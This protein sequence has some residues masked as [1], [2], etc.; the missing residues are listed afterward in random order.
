MVIQLEATSSKPTP[1]KLFY[2][3]SHNDE[4]FRK[5]LETHLVLLQREGFILDWHDRKIRPGAEW[6]RAISDNL[7]AADLILL[8]VS[9]SFLASKYCRDIEVERAMERHRKGEAAVVPII[10]KACVYSN[11]KFAKLEPLPKT[12]RPL[13]EWRDSGFAQ[14]VEELRVLLVEL[15]YPRSPNALREGMH[16]HWYLKVKDHDKLAEPREREKI[17]ARLKDLTRDFTISLQGFSRWQI[18]DGKKAPYETLLI[19]NGSPEAF[20]ALQREK[21]LGKLSPALGVEVVSLYVGYAASVVGS[22]LP[23]EEGARSVEDGDFLLRPGRAVSP[24]VMKGVK[25]KDDD[26]G[27]LDFIVDRG[28]QTENEFIA[29]GE[30]ERHLEYFHAALTVKE[31]NMWVNL[32]AYEADRMLPKP[33]AGTRFG[34]DLLAQDVVLKQLTSSLMHPDS[35]VGRRYWDAVYERSREFYGTSK[36]PLN[37]FQKVWVVP[38]KAVVYEMP[39]DVPPPKRLKRFDVRTGQRFGYIVE[40]ELETLCE[41]DLLALRYDPGYHAEQ[42]ARQGS[43]FPVQIF[44]DLVLPHIQ[45]EVNEGEHFVPLRQIY[46]AL[47][48]ATWF[49]KKLRGTPAYERV[50]GAVDSDNPAS[51]QTSVRSVKSL[52]RA[53]GGSNVGRV[54]RPVEAVLARAVDHATPDAPAFRIADNVEFYQRYIRLFR[55]GVFR[56]ARSE[57]GDQPGEIINRMYFSGAIRFDTLDLRY[58]R[59]YPNMTGML[60]GVRSSPRET[61]RIRR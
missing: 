58:V 6:D 14:V 31:E 15:N 34:R 23:L 42:Y 49:K 32:S 33:L 13:S 50:L 41:I 59:V 29:G 4:E 9:P 44:K 57:A 52:N 5:E 46:H 53:G 27:S 51:L 21:D 36:I 20:V 39:T 3:Y 55:N 2:S 43:D 47:I 11:E 37:S 1:R 28:D 61:Q 8:L 45:R 54:V 10:L 17:V 35:P 24:S 48:L 40:T 26:P 16:G 30:Y 60:S 19:L 12:G 18:T 22:S 7:N 38:K 25:V 56:C